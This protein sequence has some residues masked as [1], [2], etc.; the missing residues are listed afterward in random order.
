MSSTRVNDQPLS[1][2]N[3]FDTNKNSFDTN[4]NLVDGSNKVTKDISVGVGYNVSIP[5]TINADTGFL[6]TM[7]NDIEGDGVIDLPE[8]L[9][10]VGEVALTLYVSCLRGK[11]VP[12]FDRLTLVDCLRIYSMTEDSN[13]LS[14]IMSQLFNR[15]TLLSP[16]LYDV[17]VDTDVLRDVWLRCPHQL[18][19]DKLLDDD[20]FM[21]EWLSYDN[22]KHV[23][24]N[25]SEVLTY[26]DDPDREGVIVTYNSDYDKV[27]VNRT[28][29]AEGVTFTDTTTFDD[30]NVQLASITLVGHAFLKEP[31]SFILKEPC[32][33][34]KAVPFLKGSEHPRGKDVKLESLAIIETR[35]NKRTNRLDKQGPDRT[36]LSD[37]KVHLERYYLDN[38]I[39]GDSI[40]YYPSGR[41]D[42]ISGTDVMRF[43]SD[44]EHHVLKSVVKYKDNRRYEDINYFPT[45]L[46]A[47]NNNYLVKGLY[48][49]DI[50]DRY[51]SF[52][53][54]IIFLTQDGRVVREINLVDVGQD[55]FDTSYDNTGRVIA[56][57]LLGSIIQLPISGLMRRL[58]V[59]V[60][61]I[62]TVEGKR[63]RRTTTMR[64]RMM[65]TPSRTYS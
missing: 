7:S 17:R 13:F 64:T 53:T 37:G 21:A 56:T 1:D 28:V 14:L 29:T 34:R 47:R 25:K 4:K 48:R 42:I 55:K 12:I 36:F 19:P 18:L 38:T 52:L 3:S 15:W 10:G 30:K 35:E 49:P 39:V 57:R 43:Y 44:D 6:F 65:V 9:S 20:H 54:T 2:K 45:A 60:S 41:V 59:P 24:L 51:S 16:A 32:S 23:T 27:T 11:E 62:T 33:F 8:L 61:V 31:C 40:I 22:N 46:Y 26:G 5:V 50:K 58:I 63:M